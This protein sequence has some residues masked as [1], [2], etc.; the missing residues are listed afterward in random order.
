MELIYAE[1][2]SNVENLARE[3]GDDKKEVM[4]YV[5]ILIVDALFD[6]FAAR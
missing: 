6:S 2:R 1:A 4:M 5:L 3:G